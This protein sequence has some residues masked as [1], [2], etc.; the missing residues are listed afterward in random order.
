MVLVE[1]DGNAR[2]VVIDSVDAKTLKGAARTHVDTPARIV[3][4]EWPSYKGLETDF[5]GHDVVC[6]SS[7]E[8]ARKGQQGES[9]DSNTAGSFFALL[10]RGHYGTFQSFSRKHNHRYC[11]E[12]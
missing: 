9:V 11:D 10:K 8:Y 6:H 12:F 5:A 1:R 3:T 4:D 7:G 2:T